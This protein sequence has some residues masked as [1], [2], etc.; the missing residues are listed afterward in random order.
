MFASLSLSLGA[1]RA[2]LFS[3]SPGAKCGKAAAAS[4]AAGA[5]KQLMA[6]III[7]LYDEPGGDE[8]N[9]P[10]LWDGRKALFTGGRS[11]R[12]GSGK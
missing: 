3:L 7:L 9:S 11:R 4:A 10:M 1:A 6:V 12:G 5:Q 2:K 8:E